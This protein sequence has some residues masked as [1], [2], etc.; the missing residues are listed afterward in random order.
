MVLTLSIYRDFSVIGAENARPAGRV[1]VC[2]NSAGNAIY[3]GR[4]VVSGAT[5]VRNARV[6]G[7][8]VVQGERRIV[9]NGITIYGVVDWPIINIVCSFDN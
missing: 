8:I 4:W 3:V 9:W 2:L 7:T 6:A 1:M 5:D